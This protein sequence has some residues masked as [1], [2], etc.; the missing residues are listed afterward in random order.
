[1][2]P[3]ILTPKQMARLTSGQWR[4]LPESGLSITGV[5]YYLPRVKPGDLFIHR[6][7]EQAN[8]S[9][10]DNVLDKA[11][12]QGAIA[13]LVL[14]NTRQ[15]NNRPLLEVENIFKAFQDLA[16]ASSF[17]FD[18]IK[19]LVT[20]SHGK[21][22][23]KT[24]LFH[25]LK[26]QF[27]VHA[28]LDSDNQIYPVFRTL[29]AI[30]KDAEI[31]IIETAIPGEGYGEDRTFFIRPNYCVITGIGMEHL[32]KHKSISNL[33]KNKSAVVIGLRPG[34][35]C[36][37]NAE[38]PHF[39]E[40]YAAVRSYSG[41]DIL[42]FGSSPNCA[43]R[44]VSAQYHDFQWQVVAD[45]SGEIIR[46]TLP[47]IEDYAP[48]AS[49]SVLLMAKLLGANLQ[50]GASE[51]PTYKNFESSGNLYEVQLPEGRFHVY[52]QSRRGEWKGFE[53]M[54]E[55]MSRLTPENAGRKIVVLSELINL[56]DNPDAPIDLEKMRHLFEC[57]GVNLLFSIH[58]FK[59]HSAIV[60]PTTEWR[61]HGDTFQEIQDD[62]ISAIQPNDMIFVRG[63]EDA[64][65]DKLVNKLIAMGKSAKKIY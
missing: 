4:N 54:F 1:M 37:L 5:N 32:G 44:L 52:D 25:V 39:N 57:A 41:C 26:N 55:L 33:I 6:S 23:F 16:L 51:Y 48:L 2:P 36:I 38:D 61:K 20:G 19:I 8:L 14:K 45:I 60:S 24:Q 47:L 31:A 29:T 42:T 62:L 64:R 63:I 34:G 3:V 43:G 35:R 28:H 65:L 9:G 13:A 50:L 17:T 46:Y 40:V 7:Q 59:E 15:A 27:R 18:G 21:T 22:G 10:E 49:V 12:Q 30:P 11:F 56:E 58:R 53:S